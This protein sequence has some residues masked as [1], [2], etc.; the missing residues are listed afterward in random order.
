MSAQDKVNKIALEFV[1]VWI[2]K[3]KDH[4]ALLEGQEYATEE[5][6]E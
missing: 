3:V 1:E 6:K 2:A 5:W 4:I